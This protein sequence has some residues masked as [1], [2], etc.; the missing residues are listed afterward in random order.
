M[1]PFEGNP[2]WYEM[3]WAIGIGRRGLL[4]NYLSDNNLQVSRVGQ[5]ILQYGTFI[6]A[7]M[8]LILVGLAVNFILRRLSRD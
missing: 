7:A 6:V 8:V 1:V 5:F 3:L 2:T 4:E